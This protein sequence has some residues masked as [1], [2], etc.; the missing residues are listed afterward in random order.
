MGGGGGCTYAC[1][2]MGTH[3]QPLLQN[4]LMDA[5]IRNFVGMKC[6]WS[7]TSVVVQ[8]RIQGGAKIGHWG[9][10]SSMNFC[11]RPEGYSNKTNA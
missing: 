6:S 4:R 9:S 5:L 2:C 11:F 7:L 1:I 8:G 3:S 10:P